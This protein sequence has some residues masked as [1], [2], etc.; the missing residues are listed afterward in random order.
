MDQQVKYSAMDT[1]MSGIMPSA[2]TSAGIDTG[3][4]ETSI[5]AA[6]QARDVPRSGAMVILSTI[7]AS[8]A[9]QKSASFL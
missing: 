2:T 6:T 8:V 9:V 1:V 7:G 4:L 5:H 3:V